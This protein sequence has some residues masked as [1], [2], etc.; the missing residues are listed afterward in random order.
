MNDVPPTYASYL[1]RLWLEPAP[2]APEGGVWQGEV[3]HIQTGERRRFAETDALWAFLRQNFPPGE[4]H[5]PP[6][7]DL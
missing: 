5:V 3:E 4:V 2:G 1:L 6:T 7:P